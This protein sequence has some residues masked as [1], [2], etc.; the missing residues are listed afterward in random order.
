[1]T[2]TTDRKILSLVLLFTFFSSTTY[3]YFR[4]PAQQDTLTIKQILRNNY[5]TSRVY[6]GATL[7]HK[8]LKTPVEER[9]LKEFSYSTPENCAKQTTVHP[10]P[11]VW[12]WAPLDAYLAFAEKNNITLRIHGPI[13]PQASQ[14]TKTDTRTNEELTQNLEEYL[15]ALCQK[16]NDNPNI[17][18]M[19]VVNETVSRDGEWFAEKPGNKKWENPWKQIGLDAAG[20]PIY[21]SRAFEIAQK[22]APKKSLV[23]NHHGGME[24]KMWERVKSTILYLKSKGY[25]L[26]GLGWQGHLRSDQPLALN[27]NSL[28][29]FAELVDWAHQNDLDFHVTEIDYK[30]WEENATP[31]ALKKQADAY[32]NI[33]KVLLSKRDNGVV[34]YNTWGMK[35]G[36]GRHK[37]KKLFIFDEELKPKPALFAIRKALEDSK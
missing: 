10:R 12:N 36:T 1:M 22:H 33:L 15:T 2:P 32:A 26:D 4:A 16:I 24:K 19:D 18:W 37:K 31:R 28:A 13:S 35:D 17:K 23:Y 21:I 7:N 3:A 20:I 30:I 8:Q 14:W 34:T 27:K 11:G 9:F 29:Y 5:N 6:V 25:R